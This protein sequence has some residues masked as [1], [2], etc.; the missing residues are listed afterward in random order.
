MRAH[1]PLSVRA[2]AAF[3]MSL[4]LSNIKS[5]SAD[6]AGSPAHTRAAAKYYSADKQLLT[7]RLSSNSAGLASAVALRHCSHFS[8]NQT[9]VLAKTLCAIN[10]IMVITPMFVLW[11]R[12]PTELMLCL[13]KKSGEVDEAASYAPAIELLRRPCQWVSTVMMTDLLC[14]AYAADVVCT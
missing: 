14:F 5:A 3:L 7:D 4:R 1:I 9:I 8:A 13:V 10:V 12:W 6:A 2:K 11:S